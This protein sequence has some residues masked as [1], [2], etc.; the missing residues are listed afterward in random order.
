LLAEI[1]DYESLSFAR[2]WHDVG[3]FEL[4]INRHKRNTHTL[5]KG[6]LVMVG[7]QP[8]KVFV[9][10]HREIS[11]DSN[12]KLSEQWVVKGTDLKGVL[13]SRIT[14][15]PSTTAYDNKQSNAE[16]VMKHYVTNNV[17]TPTDA[18]RIISELTLATNQSR[19]ASVSWRSRY[20]NLAEELRDISFV[21][22]IGWNIA[23]DFATKKWVFDVKVGVD[24]TAQQTVNPP[25]IFSPNFDAVKS[26]QF[27]DSDLNYKNYGYV[28]GQGE[29]TTRSI[30]EVGSATGLA[31][32]E[33]FID[34]RDVE[35]ST[36]LPARGQQKLAE[37][38]TE[39]YLESQI[40]T[41]SPFKY[42][43]DYDLGDLVTAQNRDWGVELHTRIVEIKE[44]YEASGG[45]QLEATF[46]NSRPTLI[47]KIKQELA[48]I[49][50]E[51]RK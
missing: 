7:N 41:N 46:G 10:K 17:I 27:A 38:E 18:N 33:L 11:L 49:S 16:T 4:R 25:V 28:G 2:R 45:F 14:I 48:Q 29:G 19:G 40:L 9:I 6:N 15:P 37:F 26:Q 13:A 5:Q 31:R 39:L 47:N 36:D 44:I 1:D 3:S 42:E 23:L 24:R 32:V 35:V 50:S 8:H 22:G 34:A 21:S 51:V 43:V 20:K 12:G 30:A